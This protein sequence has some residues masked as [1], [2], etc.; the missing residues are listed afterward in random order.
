MFTKLWKR[1][2]AP[3]PLFWQRVIIIA[4]AVVGIIV[5]NEMLSDNTFST[6]ELMAIAGVVIVE[7]SQFTTPKQ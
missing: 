2:T 3:T 6:Q 4:K 1:Y 5:A 7:L